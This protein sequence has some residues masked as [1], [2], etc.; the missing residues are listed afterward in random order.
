M[1]TNILDVYSVDHDSTFACITES[2]Q[3]L[4]DGALACTCAANDTDF[5]ARLYSEA[6]ILDRGLK[7]RSV[8]H[9]NILENDLSVN[10][11]YL[12]PFFN[13]LWIRNLG[14]LEKLRIPR[15]FNIIL[16]F[17]LCVVVD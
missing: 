10:G 1:K 16:L 3:D 15:L 8:A 12:S 2:E 5:H 11:P 7:S 9:F 14:V 13:G 4:E 6:Q 17:Q